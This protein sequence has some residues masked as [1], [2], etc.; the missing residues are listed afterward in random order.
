MLSLGWKL[1]PAMNKA[2]NNY[3]WYGSSRVVIRATGM[4]LGRGKEHCWTTSKRDHASSCCCCF[5]VVVFAVADDDYDDDDV[6][7]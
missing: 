2:F 3:C 5:V 7:V 6:V 1:R 4:G